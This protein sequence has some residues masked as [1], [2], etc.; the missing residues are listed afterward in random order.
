MLNPETSVQKLDS[1]YRM[2]AEVLELP[3]RQDRAALLAGALA[4]IEEFMDAEF[5]CDCRANG[6]SHLI[7]CPQ[8]H[9]M[10]NE[11]DTAEEAAI[12]E[13]DAAIAA[14]AARGWTV[15]LGGPYQHGSWRA[16]ITAWQPTHDIYGAAILW[17]TEANTGNGNTPAA[18]VHAAMRAAERMDA[19]HRDPTIT[20]D[21]DA[22][23]YAREEA[24]GGD[25]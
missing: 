7:S 14:V 13:L 25:R 22:P 18:A 4:F 23:E 21:L 9:G 3:D 15:G 12:H 24:L 17:Q 19:D 5:R 8:A 10:T 20:E 1:A 6:G 16:Y 11:H 2:V